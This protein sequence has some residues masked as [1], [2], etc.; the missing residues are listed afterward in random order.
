MS[1]CS[2]GGLLATGAAHRPAGVTSSCFGGN[3]VLRRNPPPKHQFLNFLSFHDYF[4]LLF[5]CLDSMF[6]VHFIFCVHYLIASISICRRQVFYASVE[7]PPILSAAATQSPFPDIQAFSIS[8]SDN[9]QRLTTLTS[10][11]V[12]V[13]I[14]FCASCCHQYDLCKTLANLNILVDKVFSSCC[15]AGGQQTGWLMKQTF[16]QKTKA[17]KEG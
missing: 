3:P 5:L 14:S 15:W 12:C 9:L 8:D 7:R 17:K 13:C 1:S 11:E 4:R 6:L 16:R 10:A 2:V